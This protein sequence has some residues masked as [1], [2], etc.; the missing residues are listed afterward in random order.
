MGAPCPHHSWLPR[1]TGLQVYLQRE[2]AN[3]TTISQSLLNSA[4]ES[5]RTPQP[6]SR[7]NRTV[8]QICSAKPLHLA[9]KLISPGQITLG[10]LHASCPTL[11]ASPP[12]LHLRVR[13]P[14]P[15][16]WVGFTSFLL[17]C[18]NSQSA[19]F[20]SQLL[21]SWSSDNVCVTHAIL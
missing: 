15:Q 19:I 5:V 9:L 18:L 6:N 8:L 13:N 7:H 14:I 20:P 2:H 4:L 1:A 17:R 10:P 16:P 21:I 12:T 11:H 3:K